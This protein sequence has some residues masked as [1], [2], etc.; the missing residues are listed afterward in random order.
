MPEICVIVPVYKVESFLRRCV[1]SILS[2]T[3]TDFA[4]VLVDDGSPDG[5]GAICDD[6]ANTDDRIHVVH[7]ENRGLSAARNAG[8]DW[9]FANSDSQWLTFIDSDDWVHP[10]YLNILLKANVD[11][12]TRI[13]IGCFIRTNGEGLPEI[14][15]AKSSV[16][17]TDS[18]FLHDP[19]NAIVAWGKLIDMKA[20]YGIRF[21]VGRIHEDEFTTYKLLFQ[22]DTVSLVEKPIYAYY[23]NED[24]IT[25]GKWSL[26][27]LDALDGIEEQVDFFILHGYEDIAQNRLRSW[28]RNC[29]NAQTR[30][31]ESDDMPGTEIH[32]K[33]LQRRM[34]MVL[35]KYRQYG[36]ISIW[37]R[38]FDWNAYAN[39]NPILGRIQIIW[40]A[41]KKIP[42]LAKYGFHILHNQCVLFQAPLYGNLGDH[43]I[44]LAELEMLRQQSISCLDFP[45]SEG[46]EE[47]CARLTPQGKT[48]LINGG[49]YLGAL[50]PEKEKRIRNTL[51]VFQKNKTII[52]PQTIFFDLETPDG[53]EFFNHSK[54]AYESHPNLTVFV[55][56]RYSYDFMKKYMPKVHVELVPDIVML[57]EVS[58]QDTVRSGALLCLRRDK[59]RTISQTDRGLLY[60]HISERYPDIQKTDTVIEGQ[61]SPEQR[62]QAVR[63]KLE[64]FLSAELVVTDRLNGMIFAAITETPCIV[65]D[66]RSYKMRGCYEWLK[67]LGYIRFAD[68]VSE[69]PQIMEELSRMKPHYDKTR[70]VKAMEPLFDALKEI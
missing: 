5:C 33:Q 1:D 44:A 53:R 45:W 28:L 46:I 18:F 66:S 7:Q 41:L 4:L 58:N 39:S 17:K 32:V 70:I 26:K 52:F 50:W 16:W 10:D 19:T 12:K 56:E 61:I 29:L 64:E 59:E 60:R 63:K 24:G 36:W 20:L 48:V 62:E 8:I 69:M 22:Y 43:A 15:D 38:G 68:T 27:R 35:K 49:G 9:A 42:M 40:K 57:L 23:Q 67:D 55:R 25:R 13:S 2:Q 54:L 31:M 6:Y 34:A 65:L 47:V 3:Y 11:N 37:N 51:R 21:P 14:N 30:I